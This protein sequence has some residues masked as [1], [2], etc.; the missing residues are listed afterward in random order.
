MSTPTTARADF[1]K[2]R[3]RRMPGDYS[4][5]ASL[6][7]QETTRGLVIRISV[8]PTPRPNAPKS[9]RGR[10]DGP[11]GRFRSQEH[12][13]WRT[14]FKASVGKVVTASASEMAGGSSDTRHQRS[15]SVSL[16]PTPQ[17]IRC[18][19]GRAMKRPLCWRISSP[20]AHES[21]SPQREGVTWR[22]G[23]RGG[24]RSHRAFCHHRRQALLTGTCRGGPA[25]CWR[26][27]SSDQI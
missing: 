13:S 25:S 5:R 21:G 16:S 19:R 6:K 1:R 22:H 7:S 17:A 8:G 26:H 18:A 12:C 24:S 23:R 10:L 27:H 9:E 3:W 14:C 11:R 15:W 20:T 4:G 2:T